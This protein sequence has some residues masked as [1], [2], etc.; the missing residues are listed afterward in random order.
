MSL[1]NLVIDNN[2]NLYANSLI[3]HETVSTLDTASVI[4]AAM[5]LGGV[6]LSNP[7]APL[8][9][10][11]DSAANIVAAVSS[12]AVGQVL[13]YLHVN[14]SANAI[15]LAAGSG[16]AITGL[17]TATLSANTSRYIFVRLTNVSSGTEA[18]IIYG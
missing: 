17:A 3:E 15:T 7:G 5:I 14:K 11:F 6:L 8:T 4:T 9:Q 13:K 12:P 18:A 10:T 16:S 2:Y 1:S